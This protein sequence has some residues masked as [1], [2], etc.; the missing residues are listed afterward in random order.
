MDYFLNDEQ[1]MIKDLARKITEEKVIP[2]R[3]ELDEKEE[4]PREILKVLADSD[5]FGIY[6]PEEYGGFGMGCFENCLVMEELSRGCCGVSVSYAA[7]ALGA[8]PILLFGSDEQKR[9]FLPDIARGTKLAAFGLTEANAGSD[10]GGI[11]TS[12]VRE[13]DYYILNGTKQWITNGG[14]AEVYII[15]ALTD[16]TKGARGASAF[17]VEKGTPGFSFGKKEKKLGIRASATRELVFENCKIP[18]KNLIGKEGLGFII[19]M[20]TLDITR[21]GIGA[22][23]VGL[24]TGAL[25]AALEYSRQRVQFGQ[26]ISS[27]QVIQ[28]MLADMATEIE[29]ARA[30]VCAAAKSIDAG[31]KDVSK[32]SAMA[33]VFA[34][35]VAMKVTIDAVQIFG[36]YG[37]MREYPVEKMMRDAKIIQIYEGTNQIQRNVIALQLIK[38]STGNK[39]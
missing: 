13:G 32:I 8:Y 21:P 17:I 3:A 9:K 19:A 6:I 18:L 15:I 23:A 25:E 38:E 7:S 24:A 10:A 1:K 11:Q 35:D 16:K 36:G 33:K 5:L 31:A 30:L 20:K 27:F 4:F 28:H 29:A 2:V 26:T 34:S 22:Q 12:V 14:E 37:Y 39:S